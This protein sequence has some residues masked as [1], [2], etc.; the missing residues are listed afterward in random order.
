MQREA[1][2][3]AAMID[4]SCAQLHGTPPGVRCGACA[5]LLDYA[6]QRLAK[7]PFQEAKTVCANC[8]VH[9]YKPEM[10]ARAREAM[11]TAGPRMPLRHPLMALRHFIDGLRKQPLGRR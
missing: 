7:C 11:R 9:C 3:V 5:E 1:R 2:T 6:L 8:R 4:I 10:R